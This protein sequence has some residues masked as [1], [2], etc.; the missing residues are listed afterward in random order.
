M[1]ELL[2]VASLVAACAL[3]VLACGPNETACEETIIAC[4]TNTVKPGDS[5]TLTSPVAELSGVT[6][7]VEIDGQ[8][9]TPTAGN[10]DH[11]DVVVPADTASGDIPVRAFN[12]SGCFTECTLKVQ[13]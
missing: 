7:R 3:S 13:K 6:T 2:I 9:V 10:G 1:K 4:P 5:I 12:E 8:E 11:V